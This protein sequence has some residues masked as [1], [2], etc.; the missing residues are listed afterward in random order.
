MP[1]T[2]LRPNASVLFKAL[3]LVPGSKCINDTLRVQ[4]PNNHILT[5]NLC[6]NYYYPNPKYLIIG[7]MDPLG[8]LFRSLK[9]IKK[10]RSLGYCCLEHRALGMFF[11]KLWPCGVLPDMASKLV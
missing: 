8:Y 1:Y 9:S 11:C 10:P 4:V 5:P 2:Y 6:Y 3:L 7:Y